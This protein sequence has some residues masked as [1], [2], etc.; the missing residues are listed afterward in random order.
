MTEK[1]EI[2]AKDAEI[3]FPEQLCPEQH[4]LTFHPE[5]FGYDASEAAIDVNGFE[6]REPGLYCSDCKIVYGASRLTS[7]KETPYSS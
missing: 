1:L 5:L 7:K 4:P 2:I 6:M 3:T